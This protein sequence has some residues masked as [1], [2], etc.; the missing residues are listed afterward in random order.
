MDGI[1]DFT[2]CSF[3]TPDL[4]ADRFGEGLEYVFVCFVN[5]DGA[6]DELGKLLDFLMLESAVEEPCLLNLSAFLSSLANRV[7]STL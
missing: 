3:P 4:S 5:S 7:F 2:L 6:D 1:L